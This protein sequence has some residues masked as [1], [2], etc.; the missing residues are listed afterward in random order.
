MF[1]YKSLAVV[2]G[3][4]S[5]DIFKRGCDKSQIR[6]QI[7]GDAVYFGDHCFPGGNDYAIS[8]L[9]ETSHQIN[10]GWQQTFSILQNQYHNQ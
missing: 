6:K 9:C 7:E 8:K 1:G 2:G 4:I 3:E 10:D 5:I